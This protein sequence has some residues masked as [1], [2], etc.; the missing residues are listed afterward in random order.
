[1]RSALA[2]VLHVDEVA[3]ESAVS[4]V[5]TS[6]KNQTGARVQRLDPQRAHAKREAALDLDNAILVADSSYREVAESVG[7]SAT[8]VAAWCAPDSGKTMPISDIRRL[9]REVKGAYLAIL[10]GERA[11]EVQAALRVYR[12]ACAEIGRSPM[13]GRVDQ[14]RRIG[15]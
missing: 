10:S 2:E 7:V 14:P 12:A 5:C 1:M 11:G 8:L 6:N 4:Q 15:R 9:P 13:V 3:D